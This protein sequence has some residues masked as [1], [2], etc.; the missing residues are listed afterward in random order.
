MRFLV[1]V[2]DISPLSRLNVWG[3]CVAVVTCVY[4]LLFI[5]QYNFY[6]YSSVIIIGTLA[7]NGLGG[8]RP[9]HLFIVV[10]VI[11]SIPVVIT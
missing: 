6:H 11:E 7:C 9:S 10:Y 1:T 2:E 3:A 5:L 4:L 8:F